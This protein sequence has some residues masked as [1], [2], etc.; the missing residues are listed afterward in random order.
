D[1]KLNLTLFQNEIQRSILKNWTDIG[2]KVIELGKDV[3]QRFGDASKKLYE[4]RAKLQPEYA[5]YT[6]I[7]EGLET[8]HLIQGEMSYQDVED[9]AKTLWENHDLAQVAFQETTDEAFYEMAMDILMVI[10]ELEQL[11][12]YLMK[13]GK[14]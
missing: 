6:E 9:F 10:R 11:K 2:Q 5:G 13:H 7:N 14:I 12:E 3:E 8:K 1:L 4:L